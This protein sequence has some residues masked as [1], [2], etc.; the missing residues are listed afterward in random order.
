MNKFR[1]LIV[2][3]IEDSKVIFVGLAYD[4]SCS[5]GVGARFTPNV[6]RD[7][8]KYLP[9]FTMNG[10]SVEQCK[11]YDYGD[12]KSCKNYHDVVYNKLK[13]IYNYGKFPLFVG[14]DHSVSIPTQKLFLEHCKKNNLEPVIIH[15]DAHPD[16]CDYYDN[17]YYSHA[18][19]NKRAIDNGYQTDCINLIGIRGYE[20]QEVEYFD[21][22][23]EIKV[24]NASSINEKGFEYILEYL[25]NTYK[26]PKYLIYLSYDIDINDPSFAPGTGTPE[27]FGVNSYELIKFIKALFYNLNIGAMDLVEISP[28][29]DNNNITS[30]LGLKTLYEIFGILSEVKK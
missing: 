26:D 29:L 30:W 10:K 25:I 23:P 17:S 24:F 18:C 16:I 11:I 7:L 9:P 12:I 4:K 21:K 1:D 13:D 19:T 8:S 14:G 20:K 22:H 6:L 5:V 28:I 3:N 27:A 2:N 15:L